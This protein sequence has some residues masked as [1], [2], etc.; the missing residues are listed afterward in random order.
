MIWSYVNLRQTAYILVHIVWLHIPVFSV[1]WKQS[2]SLSFLSPLFIFWC[3]DVSDVIFCWHCPAA[4]YSTRDSQQVFQCK[5]VTD[6]L[7]TCQINL[8][9]CQKCPFTSGSNM[10]QHDDDPVHKTSYG[11]SRLLWKQSGYNLWLSPDKQFSHELGLGLHITPSHVIL[12]QQKSCFKKHA[13]KTF[14]K[15]DYYS[16]KVGRNKSIL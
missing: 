3:P 10:F 8:K 2:L 6:I 1:S 4:A 15:K 12:N 16:D 13:L 7:C 5:S 11:L 14:L 9:T